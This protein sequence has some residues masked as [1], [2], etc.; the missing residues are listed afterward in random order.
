MNQIEASLK[1]GVEQ[2]TSIIEELPDTTNIEIEVR[3]GFFD[4]DGFDTCSDDSSDDNYSPLYNYDNDTA[5]GFDRVTIL[6]T[7]STSLTADGSDTEAE[8]LYHSDSDITGVQMT[9]Y[10]CSETHKCND[11][12]PDTD[13]TYQDFIVADSGIIE[14]VDGFVF[15]EVAINGWEVGGV[16]NVDNDEGVKSIIVYANTSYENPITPGCGVL[17]NFAFDGNIHSVDLQF[18]S[19]GAEDLGFTYFDCENCDGELSAEYPEDFT[20]SQNY[21]NPFNPTTNIEF[22][23]VNNGYVELV[24]YDI[25]GRKIKTLASEFMV[26]GSHLITWDARNENGEK[27]PSG[28]YLYQLISDDMVLSKRMTLLK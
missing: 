14:D 21:P 25:M 22:T 11:D 2:L 8:I 20:L 19:Y 7:V 12:D 17:A 26:E 16:S 6:K 5:S 15:D 10:W 4:D 1:E 9:I 23:L 24:V 13:L 28:V 27:A 3:L 18:G